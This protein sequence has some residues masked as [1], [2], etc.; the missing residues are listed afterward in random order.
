MKKTTKDGG[1]ETFAPFRN[2]IRVVSVESFVG[3]KLCQA[4]TE[5]LGQ[6]SFGQNVT[7]LGFFLGWIQWG[8]V[9]GIQWAFGSEITNLTEHAEVQHSQNYQ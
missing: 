7:G 6:D 9:V 5:L 1:F 3:I 4:V 8:F 2:G